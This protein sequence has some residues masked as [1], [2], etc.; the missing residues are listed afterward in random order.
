MDDKLGIPNGLDAYSKLVV[1]AARIAGPAT[2]NIDITGGRGRG[3]YPWM[4]DPVG[5]ASGVIINSKGFIITNGHVAQGARTIKVTLSDGRSYPAKVVG[6]DP[7]ND[8]ALLRVGATELPVAMLGTSANLQV[9]QLVVAIGNPFGFQWTVTS[10]VVSAVHRKIRVSRD[11]ALENLI[12]TDA[13]INP[14]NSGGPLVNSEGRVVG[15]NT[16]MLLGAQNIGFAIAID[17]VK[18]GLGDYLELEKPSLGIVGH[19]QIID[20]NVAKWLGVN[21]KSGVLVLGVAEDSPAER[22]GLHVW[23]III[24]AGGARVEDLDELVAVQD[25]L[26]KGH[27]VTFTVIRDIEIIK[28]AMQ[29]VKTR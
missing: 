7:S 5:N 8:V 10:G 2:V 28:L 18:Q 12:Q 1:R 16:A 6:I 21:Q 9:G 15:I 19:S 26:E 25:Y 24:E 11:I 23:D 3:P 27:A 20:E 14:G 4:P 29:P 13:S 17:P 22:A